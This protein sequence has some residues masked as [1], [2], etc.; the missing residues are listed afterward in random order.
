MTSSGAP[1]GRHVVAQG[2]LEADEV[3]EHR[4]DPA[5]PAVE[6]EV[7]EVDAVD[8]DGAG[9]GVVEA[10]EQ[11]GQRG[12]ARAVLAD[13]GQRRPGRD[14]Q[15]EA[16]RAPARSLARVGEGDVAEADLAR[17]ACPSAGPV[18]AAQ[19][20]PPG[21]IGLAQA[22][23]RGHRGGGAVE[24]PV[25]AAEGDH[26]DVPTAA[27]AKATSRPRSRRPSAAASASDQNTTRLAASDQQQAPQHRAA[28]AGGWPRTA[29][30]GA[31]CG[32]RRS[33]RWS[34]PPG[35]TGAAPWP[36]AGRPPGG[37][38][39]R[40]RAGPRAPPRC[41]GPSRPPL[42]R[43]S[44]WV[45]SQAPAS[46]SGAHQ[47]KPNSTTA[48]ARPPSSSTSPAAMKSIEM[49]QRRAGH[50]QVEV[51]GHVQVVGELGVL[52]VAHARRLDAG[53]GELGRRARPQAV[54]EVG[55]DRLVDRGEH[56]DRTNTTPTK[57]SGPARS[58][59]ACT[60]PTSTPIAMANRAG[61]RP[62]ATSTTHQATAR[63]RSARGRTAKN[64]HSGRSRSRRTIDGPPG[65]L[66]SSRMHRV[67]QEGS[68]ATMAGATGWSHFSTARCR[69]AHV[70]SGDLTR[71]HDAGARS[72]R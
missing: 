43:S 45:A 9:L 22:Q 62:R 40:R 69:W 49:R 56:L 41:C 11:L 3:L 63:G 26:A 30:R 33:G 59:P 6:V 39:T 50:A 61:R 29:A 42:S 10:A 38:R 5:A 16:R 2:Q 32:G 57:A 53:L 52:E 58:S 17:R 8:L 51:A 65:A 4:G 48:E 1:R 23:D 46:T 18:A 55:A 44:Q 64:F 71:C 24:R 12:L 21:A 34:S 13:D 25:E 28:P 68:L 35:R 36:P 19:R 7:A 31:A 60:A 27:W 67:D 66:G 37:R 15:V 54:A 72:I 47:A 14:G 70:C 20:A